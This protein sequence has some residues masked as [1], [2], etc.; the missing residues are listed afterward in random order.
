MYKN[1]EIIAEVKTKSPFGWKSK[2]DWE[3]LFELANRVGDTISIHTDPRWGGSFD[4]VKKAKSMTD[5]PILAKGIHAS[6]EDIEK[7]VEAGADWV[8]VVGRIPKV[9]QDKCMFEPNTLNEIFLA[10][11]GMRVV[12]NSRDLNT[13][14]FK[15]ET[16]EEARS[17]WD[18]WLCQAS[19][20]HSIHD[21]KDGASAVL[22]GANL[23]EF[24][25]SLKMDLNKI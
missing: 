13:G 17:K 15:K 7:A 19:N 2:H 8:L 14:G 24:I 1:I 3:E 20:L 23:E 4:F 12:W 18:G 5:K 22:I 11:K 6:D 16:F 10:P 21:I 9:H 25:E